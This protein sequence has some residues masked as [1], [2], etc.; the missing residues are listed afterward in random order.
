MI[1]T[2]TGRRA[3]GRYGH[4][5]NGDPGPSVLMTLG[6]CHSFRPFNALPRKRF[7]AAVLRVGER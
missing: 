2:G 5:G 1:G 7:A 4:A 6:F 3:C